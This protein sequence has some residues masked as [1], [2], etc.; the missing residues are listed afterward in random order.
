MKQ[1]VEDKPKK[2]Q[3]RQSTPPFAPSVA[4]ANTPCSASHIPNHL[5][6]PSQR[7]IKCPATRTKEAYYSNAHLLSHHSA[8]AP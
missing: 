7:M 1:K 6:I 8:A 2:S 5:V 3:S 4:E